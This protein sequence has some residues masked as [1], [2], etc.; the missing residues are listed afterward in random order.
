[1]NEEEKPDLKKNSLALFVIIFAIILVV[2]GIDWLF[3]F[4]KGRM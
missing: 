4:F 1:M 3:T 2:L